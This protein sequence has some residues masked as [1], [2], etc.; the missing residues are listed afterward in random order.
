MLSEVNTLIANAKDNKCLNPYF[1]GPCSPSLERAIYDQCIDVL[2]LILLD[3]ALR[4]PKGT[5]E[6]QENDVLILI[7]LDH[8]LREQT[9][10]LI[11]LAAMS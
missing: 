10:V 8:A 9:K 2:I 4:V 5:E 7:L 11:A 3:H 1:I 6:N